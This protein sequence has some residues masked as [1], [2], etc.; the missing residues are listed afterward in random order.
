MIEKL[1]MLYRFNGNGSDKVTSNDTMVYIATELEENKKK[2]RSMLA[3][4]P[5]WHYISLLKIRQTCEYLKRKKFTK[6]QI[7]HNIQVLLY[8]K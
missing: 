3:R 2:L 8:P 5:Y 6:E 7:C 1:L 4:H